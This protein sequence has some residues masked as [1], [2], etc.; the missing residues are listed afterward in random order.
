MLTNESNLV[1]FFI[2]KNNNSFFINVLRRI[3]YI[4]IW[5]RANTIILM[6]IN[7][8]SSRDNV[9]VGEFGESAK[10]LTVGDVRD[11]LRNLS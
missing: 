10:W 1:F 2:G 6:S 9:G 5:A 7:R 3:K 11:G 4:I 8:M